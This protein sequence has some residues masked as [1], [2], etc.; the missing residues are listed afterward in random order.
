MLVVY[1]QTGPQNQNQVQN[2]V[3]AVVRARLILCG[4]A[5][6]P[7]NMVSEHCCEPAG[8]LDIGDKAQASVL[9]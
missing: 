7:L 2:A 8:V 5:Q 1:W 3:G 4:G 6:K 9:A